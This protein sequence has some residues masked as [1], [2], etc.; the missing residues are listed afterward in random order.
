MVVV[1]VVGGTKKLVLVTH[2]EVV[3]CVC[4][5][6]S[7]G[8]VSSLCVCVFRGLRVFIVVACND[9]SFEIDLIRVDME[10]LK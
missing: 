5:L 1:V 7:L 10:E 2:R 4:V 9:S 3:S 6:S 8:M